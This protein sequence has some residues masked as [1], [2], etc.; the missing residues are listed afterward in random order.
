MI[1]FLLIIIFSFSPNKLSVVKLEI[2]IFLA[3]I[4][5]K[6]ILFCQKF[7]L[8]SIFFQKFLNRKF[9]FEIWHQKF[10]IY[11]NSFFSLILNLFWKNNRTNH[12]FFNRKFLCF[13]IQ[14]TVNISYISKEFNNFW[15]FMMQFAIFCL[16]KEESNYFVQ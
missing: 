16:W 6:I 9:F 14:T 5:Y 10:F 3:K 15:I 11:R 12:W 1:T 13:Y 7:L 4:L 8:K 2:N